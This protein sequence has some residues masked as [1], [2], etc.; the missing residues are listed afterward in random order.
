MSKYT[1]DDYCDIYEN[2][3]CD[4]CGKCL[5][6]EGYDT[7]AIKIED[8]AKTVDENKVLE[9]EYLKELQ[10]QKDAEE[11][12]DEEEVILDKDEELRRAYETFAEENNFDFADKEYEDAFDHI[13]YEENF[14]NE[15]E[16]EEMTVEIFPGVRVLRKKKEDNK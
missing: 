6:M 9:E 5:E 4:N 16:L 2:K 1:D 3:I 8:I 14:L 13:D 12:M 11:R 7:K 10:A 15:E